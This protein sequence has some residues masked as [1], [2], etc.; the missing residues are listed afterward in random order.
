M[1]SIP[2]K[3]PEEKGDWV[4]KNKKVNSLFKKFHFHLVEKERSYGGGAEVKMSSR[5]EFPLPGYLEIEPLIKTHW[6]SKLKTRDPSSGSNWK[7]FLSHRRTLFRHSTPLSLTIIVK[8]INYQ[9]QQYKTKCKKFGLCF[10]FSKVLNSAPEGDSHPF[11]R[12]MCRCFLDEPWSKKKSA[13]LIFV[14][15][16][17]VWFDWWLAHVWPMVSLTTTAKK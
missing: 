1:R 7:P 17:G 6:S 13:L 2:L 15:F 4:N 8:R 3:I 14:I 11:R 16:C 12:K 10:F 9:T 5:C